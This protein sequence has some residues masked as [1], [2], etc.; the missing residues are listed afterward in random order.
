MGLKPSSQKPVPSLKEEVQ[1]KALKI[2]DSG[3]AGFLVLDV[4]MVSL[5][6]FH[7]SLVFFNILFN[8]QIFQDLINWLSPAFFRFYSEQI[9]SDFLRVDLIFISVYMIDIAIRWSVAILKKTY[10]R[11]F[12][13][14]FANWYDVLG[15]I[16]I[17]AFH[18]LRLF[19]F[20][21]IMRRLQR[22]GV[23]DLS[24]TYLYKLCRKYM[25][26]VTEEISDRVVVQVLNGMQSEIAR[27]TPLLHRIINE[28]VL[29]RRLEIGHWM[30]QRMTDLVEATFEHRRLE[31]KDTIENLVKEAAS[32]THSINQLQKIPVLGD[33]V[34]TML[35]TSVAGM[36]YEVSEQVLMYFKSDESTHAVHEMTEVIF[37]S[38]ADPDN[39]LNH[40]FQAAMI[41][42]IELVKEQ[43]KI[44]QWKIDHA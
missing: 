37:D 27:G 31:I 10:H 20:F 16:P 9:H 30:S 32:R 18:L 28:V 22:I 41:D 8:S 24:D 15:C 38:I 12:F 19:R 33:K 7:L 43:V 11:W 26:V 2:K 21:V 6:L 14:P 34:Q 1:D 42:A 23:L 44:Q 13:F 35:E 36:V 3:Q 17:G 29:T 40:I 4:F 5:I 39:Q 25:Q